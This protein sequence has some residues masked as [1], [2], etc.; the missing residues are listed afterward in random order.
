ML[1]L[2]IITSEKLLFTGE[3]KI[4]KLPGVS[5]SFEIMENHAPIISTLMQGKI[6]VKEINDMVSY[7]EIKGGLV[8]LSKNDVKVLVE[9]L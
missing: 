7:F 9:E 8:E 3:I 2:E 5:G 1:N 4:V 6:K